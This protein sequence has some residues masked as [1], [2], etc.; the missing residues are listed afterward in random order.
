MIKDKLTNADIYYGISEK[1]TQGLEWLKNNNLTEIPD[2]KYFIDDEKLY[3]NI[4][5]YETKD[6]APFEA[7][8]KYADI[9]YMI[10]GTETIG[11]THYLN[12]STIDEYNKEKDIEF[13]HCNKFSSR[14]VLNEGEFCILYPQDAHQPSLHY[15]KKQKVK[16][17]VVKVLL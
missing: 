14:Q 5:T 12:C 7:H 4:Q 3:V 2:G 8:R 1:L 17:A 9:Q 15:D 13:L 11:I 10:K 16:K 6:D